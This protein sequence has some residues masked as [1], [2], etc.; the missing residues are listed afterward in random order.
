MMHAH[1]PGNRPGNAPE[2]E[3]GNDKREN[4]N[5]AGRNCPLPAM[6]IF[7]I[8]SLIVDLTVTKVTS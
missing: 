2:P 8:V 6:F 1:K 7:V 4:K 3:N 5:I